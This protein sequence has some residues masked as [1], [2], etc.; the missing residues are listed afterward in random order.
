VGLCSM[1]SGDAAAASSDPNVDA[2]A[3]TKA[4]PSSRSSIVYDDEELDLLIR[5]IAKLM[6]RV[7]RVEQGAALPD[8]VAFTIRHD[9]QLATADEQIFFDALVVAREDNTVSGWKSIK[10][11]IH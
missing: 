7:A 10:D 5:F 9:D 11:K 4:A 6:H 2:A 1:A 8:R 3:H